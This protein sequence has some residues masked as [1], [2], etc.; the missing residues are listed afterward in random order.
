M[1]CGYWLCGHWIGRV[2]AWEGGSQ[3]EVCC[4]GLSVRGD[5]LCLNAPLWL[6]AEYA[7]FGGG[8]WEQKKKKSQP[9]LVAMIPSVRGFL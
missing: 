7:L 6:Q 2:K 9:N 8:R 3:P 1:P 5:A 4:H